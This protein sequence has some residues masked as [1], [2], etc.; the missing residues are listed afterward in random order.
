MCAEHGWEP[1]SDDL[2]F[3]ATIMVGETDEEAQ[4]G[5]DRYWSSRGLA[6]STPAARAVS[7]LAGRLRGSSAANLQNPN[8]SGTAG[9][10]AALGVQMN[11]VG[12][13]D[14]VFRQIKQYHDECGVGIVDFFPRGLRWGTRP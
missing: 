2:I 5:V 10:P 9:S 4:D 14:T 8:M 11:F 3:R 12:N 13:P 6:N 1:T 7:A